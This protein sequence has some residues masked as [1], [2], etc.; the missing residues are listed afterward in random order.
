MRSEFLMKMQETGENY[1]L[2]KGRAYMD[3]IISLLRCYYKSLEIA[4]EDRPDL[5]IIMKSG[6]V[7]PTGVNVMTTSGYAS[8]QESCS[9]T[10]LPKEPA[11]LSVMVTAANAAASGQSASQPVSQS[12]GG[13]QSRKPNQHLANAGK[14]KPKYQFAPNVGTR[15]I[16]YQPKV[17]GPRWTCPV[18]GH[19]GHT[20]EQCQDFWGAENCN[21]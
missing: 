4:L 3:R 13:G 12:H 8:G 15:Q 20:I 9:S 7:R 2:M 19:S 17:R 16:S 6:T 11:Q 1:Y 21:R 14:A 5:P 18:K 10:E